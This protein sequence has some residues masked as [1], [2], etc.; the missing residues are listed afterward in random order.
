MKI[1]RFIAACCLVGTSA[2]E[3]IPRLRK[4]AFM[5]EETQSLDIMELEFMTRFMESASSMA[6][7]PSPTPRPVTRAPTS[8][9]APTV[10]TEGPTSSPTP[11]TEN[12]D[13]IIQTKC[14][15]TALER[16][17]DIFTILASISNDI[18]LVTPSSPQFQA[19]NWLDNVDEAVICPSDVDRVA[20]RYRLA[21]LY[22]GTTGQSWLNCRAEFHNDPSLC[23]KQDVR[24]SR[25]LNDMMEQDDGAE[26]IIKYS[27]AH[28]QVQQLGEE[29]AIRWLS[30]ENECEWFGLDCGPEVGADS[31]SADA[32]Y[33]LINLDLSSNNLQ[34]PLL[35]E[36]FGFPEMIGFF[37]DGNMKIS[38]VIPDSIGSMPNLK[39]LDMDDNQIRGQLPNSLFT[40][41][42]LLAIDLN[43]NQMIGT[44]SPSISNIIN[45]E[46]LQLENNM[47]SG[48]LPT[49]EGL[50]PL[51]RLGMSRM[52]EVNTD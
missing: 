45:L 44:L 49:E 13:F 19:R 10:P 14:G 25:R 4:K 6:P 22:F 43:A 41:T 47:F 3:Q 32:Y 21:L 40:L 16:S 9:S 48:D 12:R 7:V 36:F 39:F 5:L 17:R 1:N 30:K 18:E 35:Q 24:S 15:T 8:P 33:P 52:M 23:L 38:G 46:V 27:R 34:G 28:R 2:A 29:E 20:Q 42:N 37:M 26:A 31:V 51:E 50:L 11:L